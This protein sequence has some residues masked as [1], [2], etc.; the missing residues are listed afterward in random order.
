MHL[1]KNKK[2]Q[3]KEQFILLLLFF[4][5]FACR[6]NE[7]P[8]PPPKKT[9]VEELLPA[10]DTLIEHYLN[11]SKKLAEADK[12]SAA[13]NILNNA[14]DTVH[15]YAGKLHPK[16]GAIQHSLGNLYNN[17]FQDRKKA[18]PHFR[19]AV[20][21]RKKIVAEAPSIDV[22]EKAISEVSKMNIELGKSYFALARVLRLTGEYQAALENIQHCL[23]IRENGH[24]LDSMRVGWTYFEAGTIYR[25]AGDLKNAL[26]HLEQAV[27]FATR[28]E[29]RASAW[30][31]MGSTYDLL[32]QP[33]KSVEYY[34]KAFDQYKTLEFYWPMGSSL[35]NLGS[36][37]LNNHDDEN[38]LKILLEAQ[39]LNQLLLEAD[40]SDVDV[41]LAK[42]S[43]VSNLG[44]IYKRQGQ[45]NKA[46]DATK[47]SLAIAIQN[48]G[49]PYHH[50]VASSYDNLGNVYDEKKMPEE[51]LIAYK[52]GIQCI[53]PAFKPVDLLQ[54]P[55][56]STNAVSEKPL[57][58][59]LLKDKASLLAEFARE[60]D[61]PLLWDM[62]AFDTYQ[63]IDTL[64]V[65]TRQSCREDGSKYFLA[66]E[67]APIYEQA[68][69][70]AFYLWENTKNRTYLD[71]V[72]TFSERNKAGVLL[73]SLNDAQAKKQLNLDDQLIKKEQALQQAIA[74]Q[75]WL[76]FSARQTNK[77]TAPL[78]DSLFFLKRK[79]EQLTRRIEK[80]LPN[81]FSQ[82]FALAE[83][84][85][86]EKIQKKLL[87]GQLLVEYF[88]GEK[89]LYTVS[90]SKNY[91]H[92]FQTPLPT[93]FFENIAQF[94]Q[95]V[96]NWDFI[97]KNKTKA[98]KNYLK[99]ANYLFDFLLKKPIEKNGNNITSIIIVPDGQLGYLSFDALLTRPANNW[100][101][102]NTP[103]LIKEYAVSYAYATQ[104]L[105]Q[106]K[107]KNR[108]NV[109][110]HFAG[111]GLEYDERTLNAVEPPQAVPVDLRTTRS[112]SGEVRGEENLR[113]ALGKLP[114]SAREVADITQLLGGRSWLNEA[115]TKSNFLQHAPRANIIHFAGH[116]F[117]DPQQ[118]LNS[119]LLFSK[120]T[121][122]TDCLLRSAD[123]YG[124]TLEA[125]LAVLSACHT[126][127]GELQKGEGIMSF[128]RAFSYVGVPS[129]VMSLWSITDASSATIM[130][131]FYEQLK[132]G[133]RKD[134]ALRQA[135]LAYLENTIPD[136]APPVY[137]AGAVLMGDG[138]ALSGKPP[139]WWL[140]GV[141]GV[142]F[143]TVVFVFRKIKAVL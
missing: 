44:I 46:L 88:L 85:S 98:E 30:D 57:L 8:E 56:L 110:Y 22:Q 115:A 40:P 10:I 133:E 68:I 140:W 62:A 38:A 137:W 77:K 103:Y 20:E 138:D 93:I 109:K 104:F 14:L 108:G 122:S 17:Y 37:Y 64:L 34:R 19:A 100:K 114:H 25:Q 43:I 97:K 120:T 91:F 92:V 9:T 26:R 106:S 33:E 4:L 54:N 28:P 70:H 5:C 101:A 81:Y 27:A 99:A 79:I 90:I 39:E 124:R 112:P 71:A 142:S 66:K 67:A 118:P 135:K 96:S 42:G 45:L 74:R 132:N 127:Y 53:V 49:T 2:N 111:F 107:N 89:N 117:T 121:D 123:L 131:A 59:T 24:P 105:F 128:A 102:K 80:E 6:Q 41:K 1:L 87:P 78:I 48:C 116:G 126:G 21:I 94:R 50:E 83:I 11:E 72:L 69:D 130:Q 95:A 58:L 23:S 3:F 60:Q 55:N 76:I 141:L 113:G 31:E 73:E 7:Q 35:A 65:Q 12:L 52:N 84:P 75:E 125:Q 139:N 18:I 32:L 51:A 143:L 13:E 129:L 63:T 136:H 86:P 119:S 47:E 82:K 15:L 134:E 29:D 61:N 16:T 36:A